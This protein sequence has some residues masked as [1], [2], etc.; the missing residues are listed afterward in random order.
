[1]A[2]R[3]LASS[4]KWRRRGAGVVVAAIAAVVVPVQPAQAA[5][6]AYP[7]AEWSEAWI[8]SPSSAGEAKLHADVLRPKG[9]KP[10]DK[11]PVIL[12]IGP[13]FNHSGQTG[14]AGA[15][16]GT[17][18]DPIG[19]NA[20]PSE[21][22]QDFV[23]GSGLLEKGYTFVMVDL[24]GFGGS[25][26]CL[27]WSGPGEKADVVNAVTWAADQPWST[28]R[29]GMYG[30]SYDGLTGLVG[31]NE[32]PP[33]LAAVVSQEPVY[34]DYRYLYGD[35]MR[36]L[37]SVAT[38]ALYD[39][40]AATPG[41]L[42]DAPEYNA[43]SLTD[44]VCLAQ[45]F[46]QQAGDDRHDSAFWQ[47][48]NLIPGAT[49]S[50]V[51]LF[52]TQGLTENNTVADG[53]QEYLENHTGY[54]R[55]WLGPW[56][57]VRGNDV[58]ETG[59]LKMGRQ[60]WFDEVM[61]FYDRYLKDQAPAVADPPHAVQTNDGVWR[62]EAQWPAADVREF[63]T[64]LHGGTYTDHAQ[65]VSTAAHSQSGKPTDP[66]VT[67]G[68]WTVSNPLPHDVHLSG[69]P[70]ASVDVTTTRPNANLVV[71]L[72][73]L[74]PDGT[75]QLITRQGHLVREPGEST[76]PLRLWSADWKLAAG[77]RI[78]VRVTDNNQD[79]WL[80]AAPSGQ[81]VTVRGGSV[82]LPFLHHRRTMAVEGAPGVQL[83]GYLEQQKAS[84]PADAVDRAVDFTL[85]APLADPPP[86]SVFTGGYVEPVGG[87]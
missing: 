41:P 42:T 74:G 7:D 76:V 81:A 66:A 13:Y 36:R 21:R 3:A 18:Y 9:L 2:G 71:D 27:D 16:E 22:F 34:D 25:T 28:G 53:M 19:P 55:S 20:G 49:G 46:A 61:R 47:E 50:N 68:V 70:R 15:V 62:S 64:P 33:G 4:R 72:Y 60:G 52:L 45:N 79:W 87:N 5:G 32:R 58:D 65:S 54:E 57:H 86:G 40:I 23:E 17:P 77:H 8:D 82:D 26:G 84:A 59:R 39:G 10:T 80:M 1:M 11:T 31:V 44:P 24:R 48:R 51:P 14:P 30:K 56:E 75:G 38:P 12:S 69:S 63:R 37:N 6:V 35:G 83:A 85:P 67:S 73:D 78:G 29:V 43:Q